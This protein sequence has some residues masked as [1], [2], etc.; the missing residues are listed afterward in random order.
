MH[1]LPNV[2]VRRPD[3]SKSHVLSSGRMLAWSE[4]GEEAAIPVLF[5][6]GAG[7][8]GTLGFGIDHLQ[9][10]N[11]R[12]IAPDR[13]GLGQSDPDPDKTLSSVADDVIELLGHLQVQEAAVAAFSQGAPFALALAAK[14]VVSRLA[15]VSG[16]DDLAKKVFDQLLPEQVRQMT[17]QA[18]SDPEGFLAMLE[19]FA[20][21]DGF[22]ELVL[23]MSSEPD[24]SV[25]GQEP[26]RSAYKLALAEGF[27]Q[28]PGGYARDTLAALGTW[29]INLAA[30]NCPMTLWYGGKDASPVHSPD[31]G[32]SL[33][34]C[35]KTAERRFFPEE[36][37]ALLWTR[38][39]DILRELVGKEV[40]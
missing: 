16:Q 34:Q 3:R 1:F 28:G 23:S 40:L 10:L 35:L 14:G 22:F 2:A 9:E 12:L 38:A 26:F 25:Y 27:R 4:W 36:G 13:P 30:I 20:E 37:G 24:R 29:D 39:R 8:A 11:V 18:A 5:L 33:A 21:P 6:T 32:A 31:F 15:I 19:G 7:M 17:R